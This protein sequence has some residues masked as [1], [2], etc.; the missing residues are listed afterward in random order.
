MFLRLIN[1]DSIKRIFQGTLIHMSRAHLFSTILCIFLL[2]GC[3][4]LGD[5]P[6]SKKKSSTTVRVV[7]PNKENLAVAKRDGLEMPPAEQ[8]TLQELPP[9][10]KEENQIA[11]SSQPIDTPQ[12]VIQSQNALNE[13][14]EQ[15]I[16]RLEASV[17]QI[18][19]SIENMQPALHKL[20]GLEVSLESL[21][22]QIQPAAGPVAQEPKQQQTP[23]VYAEVP[24]G[25]TEY[26]GHTQ[27]HNNMPQDLL[28]LNTRQG[29]EI[30]PLAPLV[31]HQPRQINNASYAG[32]VDNVRV[33]EHPGK[34]RLVLDVS[35]KLPFEI[36][37][38][39]GGQIIIINL[40]QA[41]WRTSPLLQISNS[42]L[43]KGFSSQSDGKGGTMFTVE[44]KRSAQVLWAESLLPSGIQGHR[45]VLDLAAI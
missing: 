16:E 18:H 27:K 14:M 10:S 30:E 37:Q 19:E 11:L 39:N 45:I 24:V 23:P 41:G 15:R 21:L 28:A 6:S 25:Y 40:P 9:L 22:G 5:W 2:S 43:V 31:E 29:R 44:L 13:T 20:A 26:K 3:S 8:Q 12:E 4:W 34:T 42:P 33:G 36:S 17:M 7:Q 32:Y 35:Q 1:I 38:R